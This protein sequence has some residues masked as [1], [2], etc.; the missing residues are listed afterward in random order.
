MRFVPLGLAVAL[1]VAI[2]ASPARAG[3]A[4]PAT[5][6]A[7]VF[8]GLKLVDLKART[9]E[10]TVTL[11]L[12]ADAMTITDPAAKKDLKTLPYAGLTVRH[13][14]SS[15][16][17][18]EAG[19][20]AAAATQRGEAPTYMGK[21]ERHWLVI[22]PGADQAILRVSTKV[23]DELKAWFGQHSVTVQEGT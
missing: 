8:S 9:P 1:V 4:A 16:P 3:Q 20:P 5:E 13:T 2:G 7:K 18:K 19:D 6:Q 10:M 22:N 11:A 14:F 12:K 21:S 15:A 23:Y 17:P